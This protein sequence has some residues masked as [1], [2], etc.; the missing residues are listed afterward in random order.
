[1]RE[2]EWVK[3]AG[4]SEEKVA[5]GRLAPGY[6]GLVAGWGCWKA[7]GSF[8]SVGCMLGPEWSLHLV[9]RAALHPV[10]VA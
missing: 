2:C 8:V 1:M 6:V 9:L 3:E 10:P 4:L 5:V 7:A